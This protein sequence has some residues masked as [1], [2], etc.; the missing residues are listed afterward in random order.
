[1]STRAPRPGGSPDRTPALTE[2]ARR[3]DILELLFW[4]RGQGF[5][6]SLSVG[7]VARFLTHEED[8]VRASLEKLVAL[9]AIER[10][11][12]RYRLS[13]DGLPEARR[14]FVD[15]FREMLADGHGECNFSCGAEEHDHAEGGPHPGPLPDGK[16][17]SR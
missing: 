10:D 16:G 14:R 13:A 11:A 3:D 12:E 8:E 7:D 17:E 9:G 15:D 1:M 2:L 5:A 4:M 6:D